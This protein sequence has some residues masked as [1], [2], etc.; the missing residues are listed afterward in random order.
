[1][2]LYRGRAFCARRPGTSFPVVS[3]P[4]TCTG[5]SRF[6][7]RSATAHAAVAASGSMHPQNG[8]GPVNMKLPGRYPAAQ[9]VGSL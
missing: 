3:P 4:W 5:R 2:D 9:G 8:S 1:M 7:R 6:P